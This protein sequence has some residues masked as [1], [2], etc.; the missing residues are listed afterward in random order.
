MSNELEILTKLFNETK[1]A[2]KVLMEKLSPMLKQKEVLEE[3][4]SHYTKLLSLENGNGQTALDNKNKQDDV[5]KRDE[6]T[7]EVAFAGSQ[8]IVDL[9][10]DFGSV[11]SMHTAKDALSDRYPELEISKN[12][13]HNVV[14]KKSKLGQ[15]IE[16]RKGIGRRPT[17]YKKTEKYKKRNK[18]FFQNL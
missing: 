11:F 6:K 13:W 4:I 18:G 15:I 1:D 8:I 2:Q 12:S 16:I 3:K 9:M 7:Q 14:K 5:I 10:D 17:T